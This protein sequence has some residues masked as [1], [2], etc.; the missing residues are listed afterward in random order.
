M[1]QGPHHDAARR[2]AEAVHGRV[3]KHIDW[4][5][6]DVELGIVRS[7]ANPMQAELQTSSLLLEEG[8]HM[9][10]SQFL[11][12]WDLNYQVQV[13]DALVLTRLPD[14]TWLA[15]DVRTS[16]EVNAGIRPSRPPATVLG[17]MRDAEVSSEAGL[18]T[19]TASAVP[20]GGGTPTV[21]VVWHRHIVKKLEVYDA[22]G[23]KI[24]FVPVFGD[25]P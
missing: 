18:L 20:A 8:V 15:F 13:G 23:V 17:D 1:S 19:A 21:T 10:L 22:A 2:A 11:R 25:L 24:G 6:R 5:A 14:E 4:T 12:W 7:I 16:R 9:F 3:G